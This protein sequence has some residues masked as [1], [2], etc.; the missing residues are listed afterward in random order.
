[1]SPAFHGLLL[2][3]LGPL[4][5]LTGASA[6][7]IPAVREARRI[8]E[9]EL[10]RADVRNEA[11]ALPSSQKASQLAQAYERAIARFEAHLSEVYGGASP[12]DAAPA[13]E[14][15]VLAIVQVLREVY[16]KGYPA[17]LDMDVGGE[18]YRALL[19]ESLGSPALGVRELE[20]F[21]DGAEYKARIVPIIEN[22]ESFLGMTFFGWADDD[23]GREIFQRLAAKR[24]GLDYST[25]RERQARRGVRLPEL[26]AAEFRAVLLA[27]ATGR[28]VS[29]TRRLERGQ[30][31]ELIRSLAKPIQ[32]S[33][34]LDAKGHLFNPKKSG[35]PNWRLLSDLSLHANFQDYGIDL[36]YDKSPVRVLKLPVPGT[37]RRVN[38]PVLFPHNLIPVPL[39]TKVGSQHAKYIYNDKGQALVMGQSIADKYFRNESEGGKRLWRDGGWWV[40]GEAAQPLQAFHAASFNEVLALTR[41]LLQEHAHGPLDAASREGALEASLREAPPPKGAAHFIATDPRAASGE[42]RFQWEALLFTGIAAAKEEILIVNPFF[43]ESRIA[44]ALIKKK[45]ENPRIA[46]TVVI[47]SWTDQRI[48][49][50]SL[51]CLRRRMIRSGI[52]VVQWKPDPAKTAYVKDAML[53]LKAFMV[54]GRLAYLGSANMTQRSLRLDFEAGY[55]TQDPEAVARLHALLKEDIL[56]SR[57]LERPPFN[58]FVEASCAVMDK[59][60]TTV[61]PF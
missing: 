30:A 10:V 49:A 59:G 54:D 34:L 5:A 14:Q 9:E 56:N 48:L 12:L 37:D 47:P 32:I 8:A 13:R 7:E 31:R 24:V 33:I 29:E 36:L 25:M 45:K 38:I 1:M 51:W 40:W 11:F 18:E 4:L 61:L 20:P 2:A 17:H 28:E 15:G 27:E 23:S 43:T 16:K 19:E 35:G 55:A 22:A 26:G 53:H 6:S 52:R 42:P 57:V 60:L 3:T 41:R 58:P 46:V 39:L 44:E 21:M 50:A